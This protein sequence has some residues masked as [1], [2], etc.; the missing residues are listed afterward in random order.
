MSNEVACTNVNIKA[1]H[2]R[3]WKLEAH[4]IVSAHFQN[5]R[6][7]G[8]CHIWRVTFLMSIVI[9]DTFSDA[10]AGH[11]PLHH[12]NHTAIVKSFPE[13]LIEIQHC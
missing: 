4:P 5:P 7:R 8:L 11:L 2:S 9:N 3:A 10:I 13:G 6:R 1:I 12:Q